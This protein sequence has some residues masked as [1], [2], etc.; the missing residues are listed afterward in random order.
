MKIDLITRT[1]YPKLYDRMVDSVAKTADNPVAMFVERD[2]VGDPR[3]VESYNRL[4]AQ[5]DAD[6]LGFVQDDIEFLEKGWDTRVKDIFAEF[7]PDI[8][9]IVG[10]TEY[11]GGG[12]FDAGAKFG[13]G[14]IAD[15]RGV[16]ILSAKSQYEK[17]K[18]VDGCLMFINRGF[19]KHVPFDKAFDGLFYWDIDL[20]LRAAEVGVTSLLVRHSKTDDLYGVYPKDMKPRDVYEDYFEKK[21]GM[22]QGAQEN[23]MCC[24][25][26]VHD[27]K[28]LGQSE[29]FRGFEEKYKCASA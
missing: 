28:R 18:V 15:S 10:A 1:R 27:Y 14:L 9:G 16:R 21:H 29:C 7:T 2:E 17:V 13:K 3:L 8:L 26:T 24:Y 19:L 6:V 22:R 4:A 5:S 25:A 23:Q 11:K 20:C 12:V